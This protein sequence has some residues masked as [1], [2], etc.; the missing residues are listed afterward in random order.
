MRVGRNENMAK[1]RA[2]KI[3]YEKQDQLMKDFR[4]ILSKLKTAEGVQDFLK[5]LLNRQERL[6]LI[7]RL[8]IAEMLED[9]MSYQE[10][11]N[12][13][14]CGTTTIARVARWLNFGRQGYK[15]AIS[16]KKKK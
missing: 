5:D 14:K 8:L 13:M 15:N 3:S 7:R 6:M 16:L 1:F 2:E 11:I 9:D 12:K 4:E 10:I